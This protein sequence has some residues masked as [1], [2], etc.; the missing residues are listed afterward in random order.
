MLE[1]AAVSIVGGEPGFVAR[2]ISTIASPAFSEVAI[3]YREYDFC[4]VS[5]LGDYR[6][7]GFNFATAA[8]AAEEI[9]A[10]RRQFQVFREMR[11]VRGF[12]LV[13]C[14]DVWDRVGEYAVQIL[15]QDVAAEESEVGFD[16]H[17]PEP[18]LVYSPRRYVAEFLED[19]VP[20]S[21]CTWL[22]W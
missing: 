5:I 12:Q 14:V 17:F 13:L 1:L 19:F 20:R 6:H 4:G 16:S 18:L 9:S 11:E 22:P 10:R 8:E 15:K 3:I 2:I 21:R 7:S